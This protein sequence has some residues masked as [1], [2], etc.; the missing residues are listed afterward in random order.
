MIATFFIEIIGAIYAFIRYKSTPITRLIIVILICLGTFQLAEFLICEAPALPGFTWAR[1]GHVAITLLPPLGILLAM[2]IASRH[3]RV[4]RVILYIAAIGFTAYFLFDDNA[5]G[6]HTCAGNYVIFE[7]INSQLLYGMYYYGLL[8]TNIFYS[9]SW[10]REANDAKV[11]SALNWLA[12]GYLAFI[13]PTTTI[14]LVEPSTIQAIPSIMCGF[15]VI[16]ALILIFAVLPKVAQP[17]HK[18][19]VSKA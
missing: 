15:A 8:S 4:A 5:L 18:E 3:S 9:F 10:A 11:R 13:L 14:N 12:V 2:H 1:I 6:M 7:S 16:F 17:R 19:T